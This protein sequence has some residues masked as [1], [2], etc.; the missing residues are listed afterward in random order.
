MRSISA[1]SADG[2]ARPRIGGTLGLLAQVVAAL[3]VLALLCATSELV[4]GLLLDPAV[5]IRRQADALKANLPQGDQVAMVLGVLDVAPS[6]NPAPLV[7]DP[8]FLWRNEPLARKTQPV[9]PLPY[10]SQATWT[11]SNDSHGYRGPV[12]PLP[13]R[14]DGVFR[15]LCVGDSI[16]FGFNVDQDDTFPRRL[17]T[18]LNQRHPGRRVE[19]VNAAVPGW[20]WL[21]GLRFYQVE[22]ARLRPDLVIAAHGTND[23]YLPVR[24]TDAE[25]IPHVERPF[26]RAGVVLRDRLMATRTYR[27][28]AQHFARPG[29]PLAESPACVEQ[30][31]T[32]RVCHR[33]SVPEIEQAIRDLHAETH[34][35]GIPL[36][37][38][39]VDFTQTPAARGEYDATTKTDI[40]LLDFVMRFALLGQDRARERASALGLAPPGPIDGPSSAAARRVVLRVEAPA[41]NA[42]MTV[43]GWYGYPKPDVDFTAPMY[44]DGTH[45]DER[46]SDGVFTAT[47]DAPPTTGMF[48]YKFFSDDTAELEPQPP[49]PSSMGNRMLR[50]KGSARGP[51]ERFGHMMLMAEQTHPDAEGHEVI[52]G[53]VAYAVEHLDAYRRFVGGTR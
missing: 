15:I 27:L 50:L 43:R 7:R 18:L 2:A 38:L 3:V 32:S 42:A 46:A 16:T 52:A 1:T 26:V 44:D 37:V 48:Q 24:V 17:E 31:R 23:Q 13:V 20:S 47:I 45:G 36:V 4:A 12:R 10:G 11:I 49:F 34:A 28:L 6:L 30:V 51:V 19:V 33:V 21:Q 5:A 35:A 9:N 53:D 14:H 22:G 29:E 41:P 39:N 40:T 8:F 25:R